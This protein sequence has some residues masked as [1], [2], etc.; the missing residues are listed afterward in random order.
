MKNNQSNQREVLEL[1]TPYIRKDSGTVCTRIAKVSMQSP[2]NA[3]TGTIKKKE[4]N[5]KNVKDKIVNTAKSERVRYFNP[6][7]YIYLT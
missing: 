7:A 5:G 1:Q 4:Y 2:E 3:T 6:N